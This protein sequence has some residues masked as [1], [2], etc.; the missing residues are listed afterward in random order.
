MQ[1]VHM[2]QYHDIALAVKTHEILNLKKQSF[3]VIFQ[4]IR[5]GKNDSFLPLDK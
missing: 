5:K 4:N 1:R 2:K 3:T